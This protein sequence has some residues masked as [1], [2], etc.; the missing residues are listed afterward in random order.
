MQWC[1]GANNGTSNAST[2]FDFVGEH[3]ITSGAVV[4]AAGSTRATPIALA[5]EVVATQLVLN[6]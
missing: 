3:I 2:I 4:E 5:L 1:K 6:L